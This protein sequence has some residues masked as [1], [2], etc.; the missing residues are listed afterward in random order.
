MCWLVLQGELVWEEAPALVA[1]RAGAGPACADCGAPLSPASPCPACRLPRCQA[2]SETPHSPGECGALALLQVER[3]GELLRPALAPLRALLLPVTNP[4]QAARFA[5]LQVHTFPSRVQFYYRL[6][7]GERHQAVA[8]GHTEFLLAGLR[9]AGLT[10]AVA[11][12]SE[13]LRV[14]RVLDCNSF[15]V[16]GESG[17]CRAVYP[18]AAMLNHR[19]QTWF[20]FIMCM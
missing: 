10:P 12:D 5:L 8:L 15:E 17:E 6:Q 2:C 14:C 1:V 11:S 4:L 20:R 9:Q 19:Y 7:E 3:A 16:G 18:L 13:I